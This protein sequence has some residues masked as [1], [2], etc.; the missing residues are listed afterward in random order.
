MPKQLDER[1]MQIGQT[2]IFMAGDVTGLRPVLHEAA[3]EGRIAGRNAAAER[4]VAAGTRRPLAATSR[5]GR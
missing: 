5:A 4:P 2:S 1:T 3:N